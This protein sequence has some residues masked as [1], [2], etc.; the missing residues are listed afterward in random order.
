MEIINVPK[1][2]GP[3]T[4]QVEIVALLAWNYSYSAQDAQF[5]GKSSLPGPRKHALGLPEELNTDVN[6]WDVHLANVGDDA[7][8]YVVKLV[9]SQN[10]NELHAWIRQGNVGA[11]DV[12]AE[13]G[14][15]FFIVE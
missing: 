13:K 5:T 12:V 15:A 14:S 6:G 1:D 9:W 3:V 7:Q 2:G 4:L 10:G 11:E 8:A